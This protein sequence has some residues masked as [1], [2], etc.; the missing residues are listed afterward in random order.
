MRTVRHAICAMVTFGRHSASGT[1]IL[2]SATCQAD[3]DRCVRREPNLETCD[4][5][6]T[7]CEELADA[8][9]EERDEKRRGY[10]EFLKERERV[11][12][13]AYRPAP[14]PNHQK[15]ADDP[16]N[17]AARPAKVAD[18]SAP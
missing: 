8:V 16:A 3:Y 9:D 12:D 10:E 2:T 6:R 4:D 11:R 5:L 14:R 15:N 7:R 17:A 13:R 1:P 18:A